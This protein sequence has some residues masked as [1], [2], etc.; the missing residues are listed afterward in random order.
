[1]RKQVVGL[2]LLFFVISVFGQKDT[3]KFDEN[4]LYQG[5]WKLTEGVA[6]LKNEKR[7]KSIEAEKYGFFYDNKKEGL[8]EVKDSNSNLISHILYKND[9]MVTEIQYVKGK[10]RS[11]IHYTTKYQYTENPDLA[12]YVY[13]Y[14]EIISFNRRGKIKQRS[15]KNEKGEVETIVY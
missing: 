2:L 4:G 3:C 6:L 7:V 13:V 11:I 8:W 9:T 15:F 5:F 12:D 14:Q 1:M 10:V